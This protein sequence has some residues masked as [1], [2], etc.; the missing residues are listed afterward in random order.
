LPV[1]VGLYRCDVQ[2][3]QGLPGMWLA[4]AAEAT[5]S[6]ASVVRAMVRGRGSSVNL[7]GF[8]GA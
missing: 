2:S 6:A 4:P 7:V 1:I 3:L 5:V 8:V